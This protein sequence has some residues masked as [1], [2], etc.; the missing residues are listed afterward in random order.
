MKRICNQCQTEMREDCILEGY[1]TESIYIKKK[2]KGFLN[3]V[4]AVPKV[5]LCTNCGCVVFYIDEYK[6]FE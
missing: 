3:S 1:G 2:V 6:D 4:Y 5:A